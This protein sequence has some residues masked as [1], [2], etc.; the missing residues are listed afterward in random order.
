MIYLALFLF[1]EYGCDSSWCCF[2]IFNCSL[3]T[4]KKCPCI[5]HNLSTIATCTSPLLEGRNAILRGRPSHVEGRAICKA[6]AFS[7][8]NFK[9]KRI[10]F[11]WT[12]FFSSQPTATTCLVWAGA[13]RGAYASPSA[14][15]GRWDNAGY[16]ML[17]SPKRGE[18]VVLGYHC[19]GDMVLR[20]GT[21]LAIPCFSVFFALLLA[22]A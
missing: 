5:W 17:M 1:I 12:L 7:L 9:I 13:E 22:L 18:T 16:A 3:T 15:K 14:V 10:S 2:I 6:K 21:V 11:T 8:S 20:M 19:P 4:P